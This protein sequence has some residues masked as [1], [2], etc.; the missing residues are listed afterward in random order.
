M[1]R[2]SIA[3]RVLGTV[4]GDTFPTH[5]SNSNPTVYYIGTLDP[6]GQN[7]QGQL[8]FCATMRNRKAP[9]A[10]TETR[11]NEATAT[12]HLLYSPGAQQMMISLEPSLDD[13]HIAKW[14][15]QGPEG[16]SRNLAQ[17]DDLDLPFLWMHSEFRALGCSVASLG[18]GS[19]PSACSVNQS[20]GLAGFIA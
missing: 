11:H 12:I 4:M 9:M 15:S 7:N 14:P 13:L 20:P 17:R 1:R 3:Q 18:N 10:W 19:F 16:R 5:N 2:R 8:L 6:L